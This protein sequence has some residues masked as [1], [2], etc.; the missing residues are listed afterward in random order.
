MN[1]DKHILSLH[2]LPCLDWY[3]I[4]LNHACEI[5]RHEHYLKQTYRNRSVILSAN[6]PLPLVIPVKK[7]G[8]MSVMEIQIENDFKWQ[9]QHWEAIQS[10]YG[11]SA[12]FMFYSDRLKP[13]YQKEYNCL[14]AFCE[15]L[16]K[17]TLA[18]LKV[19]ADLPF[20]DSF[21][22]HP[23]HDYRLSI[24]PKQGQL[25]LQKSYPQVFQSKFGFTP[26]LSILD[27]IFNLGPEAKSYLH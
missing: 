8:N 1:S 21:V 23:K 13:Y 9:K 14:H 2:Y 19:Q 7:K 20:T 16:I 26:G 6:G 25:V 22:A 11:A 18:I 15:D 4:F 27:L 10:A 17:E 12:F 5:D 3:H 24:H